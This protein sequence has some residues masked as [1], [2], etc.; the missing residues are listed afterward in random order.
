MK[1]AVTY[2]AFVR[3]RFTL[4]TR[5]EAFSPLPIVTGR[6]TDDVIGPFALL[7][8]GK[9]CII[10]RQCNGWKR[11]G[12]ILGLFTWWIVETRIPGIIPCLTTHVLPVS[13]SAFDLVWIFLALIRSCVYLEML[14]YGS[15]DD[16][17]SNVVQFSTTPRN[18]DAKA[19]H[20]LPHGTSNLGNTWVS[21][22]L[23]LWFS[24]LTRPSPHP[25]YGRYRH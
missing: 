14:R 8:E 24:P 18:A 1:L 20:Y 23:S 7:G 16:Q 11:S 25:S 19:S 4:S 22:S 15:T 13:G 21:P 10:L 5:S 17:M 6:G 9:R 2:S 12:C 3:A